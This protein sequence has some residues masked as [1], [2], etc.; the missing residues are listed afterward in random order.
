MH[1]SYEC[2]ALIDTGTS[3]NFMSMLVVNRL[4]W[5]LSMAE[6]VKV[7]FS[8]GKHLRSIVQSAGLV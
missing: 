2:T 4:G 7:R 1:K 6:P 8:N 5:A 3:F